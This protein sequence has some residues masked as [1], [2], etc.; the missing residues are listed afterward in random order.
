MYY[1]NLRRIKRLYKE[2]T[3]TIRSNLATPLIRD[4]MLVSGTAPLSPPNSVQAG[5]VGHQEGWLR[6]MLTYHQI[7]GSRIIQLYLRFWHNHPIHRMLVRGVVTFVSSETVTKQI[8]LQYTLYTFKITYDSGRVPVSRE[9]PGLI[10]LHTHNSL[11][12][13]KQHLT[14]HDHKLFSDNFT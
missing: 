13:V 3:H 4:R 12:H 8:R 10:S 9:E 5:E 14:N 2:E 11:Y 6:C 7:A 1:P